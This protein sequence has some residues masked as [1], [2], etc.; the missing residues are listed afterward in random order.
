MSAWDQ[1]GGLYATSPLIA[2]LEEVTAGW[3]RELAGLPPSMSVGFVTGCQMASFTALAAARHRVLRD[4]GWDV[5]VG[6]RRA[7][8]ADQGMELVPIDFA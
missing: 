3:L 4:A 5:E 7:V 2:A 1:N 8:R 6:E